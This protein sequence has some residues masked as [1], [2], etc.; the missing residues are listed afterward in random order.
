MNLSNIIVQGGL[1]QRAGENYRDQRNA[2]NYAQRAREHGVRVMEQSEALMPGEAEAARLKQ[3]IEQNELRYQQTIQP[4]TQAL[5]TGELAHQEQ[6]Q[7]GRQSIERTTQDVQGSQVNLARELQPGQATLA[8]TGQQE[9]LRAAREGQLASLWALYRTGDVQGTLDLLNKS[10]MVAPGRKFDKIER[11]AVPVR[12]NDGKPVTNASGKPMTEE[13]MRFVAGDGKEDMFVPVRALDQL[14]KRY[15]S[16]VQKVGENLVQFNPEGSATVLY[17]PTEIAINPE[18]GQPYV[19][20]GAGV[21]LPPAAAGIRPPGGAPAAAGAAPGTPGAPAAAPPGRKQQAHIDA[22][23][24]QLDGEIRYFLTGSN[25]FAPMLPDTQTMYD[26][27]MS[28]AGPLVRS[29]ADPETARQKA[30]EQVK[31]EKAL[32]TAGGGRAAAFSTTP[33]GGVTGYTGPTPWK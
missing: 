28:I 14:W 13:F 11:G 21:Q 10:E 3:Q 8:R 27:L 4:R 24:K 5:R 23:M 15:R 17:S 2:Q 33:G 31:R 9:Q 22:R 32:A 29:G 12:G 6:M 25:T 19:K 20:K 18:T 7:P 16:S 26:K 30:I 1:A